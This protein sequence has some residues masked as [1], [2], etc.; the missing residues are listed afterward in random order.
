MIDIDRSS[1][2]RVRFGEVVV[3]SKEAVRDPAAAGL[4]RVVAL[5]HIEPGN[6]QLTGWWD[7]AEGTTFTRR[8]RAG[9]T[10]FAKRR[11]Y[12][13]KV[14]RAAF[15]GVCSGDILVFEARGEALLPELLPF[16]V[17]SEAFFD[18]AL[19]TSAGS[20]SPRTKWQDLAT[21][22]FDLPPL[23][24]Q[25]RIAELLWAMERA[26]LAAVGLADAT[27]C[28][29]DALI[30]RTARAGGAQ[31]AELQ[32]VADIAS[33]LTVNPRRK[34]LPH[35]MPYL[36][37]AN[38]YR[39]RLDLTEIKQIGA[40]EAEI[41]G[42]RLK[43]G[44]VLVVEGHA[45]F[46]QVG[47]A[48]LWHGEIEECVHQNHIFRIR[49]GASVLSEYLEAVLNSRVGRKHFESHSKSTSGLTTINSG[50]VKRTPIAVL[51][52]RAQK[53]LVDMLAEHK[54]AMSEA[55]ETALHLARL[56]GVVSSDI[57]GAP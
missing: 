4:D 3:N 23:D 56:Q 47:R 27:Q 39:G 42:K 38:V 24:Q 9:Q 7:A 32:G 28:A 57:W 54:R 31:Q 41:N 15:D 13:R 43:P 40:T 21:W 48:A 33:G 53:Q 11:A 35:C 26:R 34:G 14:A 50:V 1:W 25:Q 8:F 12:Q 29:S 17:R 52:I 5:E 55:I 45:D 49:P 10:L 19:R 37:V 2:A 36:R 16:I 51:P 6:L 20:L 44:D 22:E 46:R 18:H 30:E